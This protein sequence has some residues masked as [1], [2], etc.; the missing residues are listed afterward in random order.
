MTTTGFESKTGSLSTSQT[1]TAASESIQIFLVKFDRIIHTHALLHALFLSIGGIELMLLI[2]FF[3]FLVKSAL[4]AFT[5]AIFFLTFFGYLLIRTYLYAKQPEQFE[6]IKNE[7]IDSC[8]NILKYRI[9][10][11]ENHL[12]LASACTRLA[13]QLQGR[14][15]TLYSLP[16]WLSRLQPS[17][18]IFSSWCHWQEVHHIRELLLTSAV[19][20]HIQLVTC[21]PTSMMPHAALANAYVLLSGLYKPSSD[22]VEPNLMNRKTPK[23]FQ[24]KFRTTAERAIEEFK[25]LN[26]YAP[27]DPWVHVQLAYSYR[28]LKMPLEEIHEYETLLR[29]KPEDT[30]ILFRLGVRYF[31]QG[32]NAQGLRIY[33]QLKRYDSKRAESLIAF[34]GKYKP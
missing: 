3:T 19:E 16:K 28:D 31:Q 21:E 12:S 1:S 17:L 27:E 32:L 9:G 7:Y 8:K 25:I 11:S 2:F 10:S 23:E 13:D 29:L 33:E 6:E 24:Q 5:L 15:R 18:D 20:E 22:D 14:E 26:V 30:D 4:L 34:Y